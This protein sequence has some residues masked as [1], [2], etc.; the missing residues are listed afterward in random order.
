MV[1]HRRLK[2]EPAIVKRLKTKKRVL[3]RFQS[4]QKDF[5]RKNNMKLIENEMQKEMEEKLTNKFTLRIR[6]DCP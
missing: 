5:A 6:F 4:A 2:T 3:I 1:L